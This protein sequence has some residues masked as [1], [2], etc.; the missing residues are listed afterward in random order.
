MNR[1]NLGHGVAIVAL[2]LA[3]P[4]IH[5]D[6]KPVSPNV[7]DRVIAEQVA[8]EFDGNRARYFAWLREQGKTHGE[9]RAEVAAKIAEQTRREEASKSQVDKK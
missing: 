7:V 4:Q 5:A 2:L 9:Y 1:K 6:V 8:K 3:A